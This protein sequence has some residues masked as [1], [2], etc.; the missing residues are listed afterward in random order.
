MK[1]FNITID[2]EV[3]KA[4]FIDVFSTV[5]SMT[6]K[7]E[8]VVGLVEKLDGTVFISFKNVY[9]HIVG[10]YIEEDYFSVLSLIED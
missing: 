6:V 10:T 9:G 8:N 2:H 5:S 7:S 4:N 1:R 3:N